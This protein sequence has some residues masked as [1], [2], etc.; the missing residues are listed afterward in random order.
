LIG[1]V[2]LCYQ[3]L[4][5]RVIREGQAA[6][7]DRLRVVPLLAL[8]CAV[9]I[10]PSYAATGSIGGAVLDPA[11]AQVAGANVLLRNEGTGA[12]RGTETNELG[13]YIVPLLPPGLYEIQVSKPG[14]QTAVRTAIILRVEEVLRI[15][16]TLA[17]EGQAT[18]VNV[19]ALAT[20]DTVLGQVIGRREMTDL[21]LNQRNFLAFALL[22]PGVT[23]PTYGSFSAK[24][25]GAIHIGGGREQSNQ[26]LLDGVDNNDPRLNQVSL[27]P[28]IE[29]IDQF[30]IQSANSSVEF[31]R[32]SAGQ[33]D[34]VLKSG[35][36]S[37]HGSLFGFVRNRHLDA[38][39][40]FARP[41]CRAG[42]LPGECSDKPSLDRKQ[43]GG[44]LGGPLIKN[45]A[46]YFVTYEGL[47]LR[48]G[49]TRQSTVPS[50]SQRLSALAQVPVQERNPSGLATLE[51][52]PLPN[53]RPDD[54]SSNAYVASPLIHDVTDQVL[55]KLN[56]LLAPNSTLSGHYAL[57][58]QRRAN[59]YEPSSSF[60]NLPGFA[61]HTPRR[62]QHVALGLT[63]SPNAQTVLATR[64]GWHGPQYRTTHESQG[65]DLNAALGYPTI[66]TNPLYL[67]HPS[68]AVA[69]FESIGEGIPV[70][71]RTEAD[72]FHAVHNTS[73][74]PGAWAG[75][76]LFRFG[77]SFRHARQ[78]RGA[79]L[80]ARGLWNFFGDSNRSPLES[81]VRGL[82][83]NVL[84][85]QGDSA[86]NLR[87][88]SYDLHFSDDLRLGRRL[89]LQA[90]VRYEFNRPPTNEDAPFTVPD[91]R[92]ESAAC[93][94]KPTCLLVPA[95]SLGLPAS[96][97]RSDRNNFGPRVG[98]AW[99]PAK[100]DGLV[101]RAAYGIYYDNASFGLMN[102]YSFNPPFFSL[103]VYPNSGGST[104]QTVV[105]QQPISALAAVYRVDPA[106]YDAYV[107]QWNFNL[108]FALSDSL[109]LE[110]A[111][112]GSKGTGLTGT[113]EMNQPP[114][115]GGPRPF[116]QHG[117]IASVESRA[118]SS[119]QS[120]Q[121]RL[122]RRLR[123]GSSFLVA[124]TWAK[125]IDDASLYLGLAQAESYA[126]QDSR[127]R[128]GERALST[129][130]TA[131]RLSVIYLQELP[132]LAASSGWTR[133]LLGSWQI[134]LIGSINSGQPFPILRQLDQSGTGAG[135]LGDQS[136][137][138]DVVAD[139]TRAGPVPNHPDPA[140]RLTVSH[141]GKA[142]DKVEDPASWFNPC[143]FAAPTGLRFGNSARNN[144]IGP[145]RANID[146]SLSKR[147]LL[148]AERYSLQL[149][150]EAF[151]LLNTPQ[152]D[153]PEHR[154]DSA[155]FA[156]V[157]SSDALGTSP[158]RQLQFGIRLE[159]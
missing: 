73:I 101:M 25:G 38:R 44:S 136:D 93:A 108:Q 29:A 58:D 118:S 4:T 77:G 24:Q 33:I 113:T 35:T 146:F 74:Q 149:R 75:R 61:S 47:R 143:A 43:F 86:V 72:V 141:G 40:Y 110:T 107:Q 79:P 11:Q 129:F 154:F 92:P 13:H 30:K 95:T 83:N 134:G 78:F 145:G 17:L 151:N 97:Y 131:H 117:P 127:T 114:E 34:M 109:V 10:C 39:N 159:F 23:P 133:G 96:T 125:S 148:G 51:L 69:G 22:A 70:P 62:S 135:F 99:S 6:L 105:D 3:S 59:P 54:P 66:A 67:G 5:E 157:S 155:R 15:D 144:V 18:S 81:L 7:V 139:P 41:A 126:P 52:Y 64:F 138:P 27:A 94:P 98:L 14:F 9:S 112:V 140:C 49:V 150:F 26:F 19:S 28:P 89:T 12:Q 71:G 8:L 119:Y 116:P 120:M 60:T 37:V 91:F 31:G 153:L 16:I 123:Q 65:Q 1:N 121:I 87:A 130:H 42:F 152:F 53:V 122:E 132:P 102:S 142:A 90:G 32:V 63:Q 85:G 2:H 48:Q 45:R 55:A 115:G 124:H 103:L 84:A 156:A 57:F 137:R 158:P 21:P 147:F 46:F 128:S 68:I 50:P 106:L 111:Y 80:Y 36:N 100:F 104:I 88:W 76:H 82:P 20:D 56:Y